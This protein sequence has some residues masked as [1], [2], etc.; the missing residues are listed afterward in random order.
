MLAVAIGST[1]MLKHANVLWEEFTTIYLNKL[2]GAKK[3]NAQKELEQSCWKG[4][5]IY[6]CAKAYGV[7]LNDTYRKTSR[8]ADR[9]LI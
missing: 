2:T 9:T 7:S 1:T 3:I 4:A 8:N 5:V 6:N